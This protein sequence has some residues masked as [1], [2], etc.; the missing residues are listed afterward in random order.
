MLCAYSPFHGPDEKELFKAIVENPVEYPR[1]MSSLVKSLL[2][3]LLERDPEKRLGGVNV[4]KDESS[5]RSHPF[6]AETNWE[7]VENCQ[8][9]P[10]FKPKVVSSLQSY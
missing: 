3:G 8:I 7:K 1:S 6:F 2:N 10:P 4:N 5:I 9:E